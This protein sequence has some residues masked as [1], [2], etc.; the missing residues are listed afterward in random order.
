MTRR[1][2]GL[3]VAVLGAVVS[4]AGSPAGASTGDPATL[5]SPRPVARPARDV[6]PEGPVGLMRV[7]VDPRIEL[8]SIVYRLAGS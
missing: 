6:S 7:V 5:L 8:M 2:V 4:L 1:G 3:L